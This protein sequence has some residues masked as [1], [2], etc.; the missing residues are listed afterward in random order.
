MRWI[1]MAFKISIDKETCIGCSAC[2]S[3]CD[4]FEMIEGDEYKAKVK[5]E[6]IDNIGCNKEAA[7]TCPVDAIKITKI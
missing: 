6:K 3:V 5:K 1:I 7:E 4:N 2:T